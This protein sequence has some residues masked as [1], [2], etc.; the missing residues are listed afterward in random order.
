MWTVIGSIQP[1]AVGREQVF[2]SGVDGSVSGRVRRRP[3][4]PALVGHQ[5]GPQSGRVEPGHRLGRAGQE[6][7]LSGRGNVP[8]LGWLDVDRPVPVEEDGADIPQAVL[9]P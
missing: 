7:E 6:D 5:Y 9:A 4:Q 8:P 1:G 3:G 2:Q